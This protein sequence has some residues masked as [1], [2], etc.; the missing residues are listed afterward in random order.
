MQWPHVAFAVVGFH[1]ER[2]HAILESIHMEQQNDDLGAKLE[3]Q[4]KQRENTRQGAFFGLLKGS[5]S[6]SSR[7]AVVLF[8][9]SVQTTAYTRIRA[10]NTDT[11]RPIVNLNHR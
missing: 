2:E 6:R 4:I 10:Y 3:L 11:R 8:R 1:N 9:S 5:C 7:K